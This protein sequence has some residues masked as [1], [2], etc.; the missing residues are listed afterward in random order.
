MLLAGHSMANVQEAL[1]QAIN[2]ALNRTGD[3]KARELNEDDIRHG[4]ATIQG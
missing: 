2:A 3:F 4:L 1:Q